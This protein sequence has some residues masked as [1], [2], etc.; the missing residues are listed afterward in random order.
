MRV[1][2][3]SIMPTITSGDTSIPT[4]M[5]AER[6]SD[7]LKSTVDCDDLIAESDVQASMPVI[8]ISRDYLEDLPKVLNPQ[9]QRR[10]DNNLALEQLKEAFNLYN[11]D[12]E[13]YHRSVT[14]KLQSRIKDLSY[15]LE[16][17]TPSKRRVSSS[18]S[19]PVDELIRCLEELKYQ[20][21]N[22]HQK[23][24]ESPSSYGRNRGGSDMLV[25][26]IL[27]A[28]NSAPQNKHPS[29]GKNVALR[30]EIPPVIKDQILEILELI[31]EDRDVSERN[32]RRSVVSNGQSL[33]IDAINQILSVLNNPTRGEVHSHAHFIDSSSANEGNNQNVLLNQV[34]SALQVAPQ[35]NNPHIQNKNDNNAI[36]NTIHTT[37]QNQLNQIMTSINELRQ[38]PTLPQNETLPSNDV[39]NNTT[40]KTQEMMNQILS[41]INDMRSSPQVS[42]SETIVSTPQTVNNNSQEAALNLIL[43]ELSEI[44]Q[45]SQQ[46]NQNHNSIPASNSKIGNSN[47]TA[48]AEIISSIN[49]MKEDI[50]NAKN[51]NFQ[52]IHVPIQRQGVAPLADQNTGQSSGTSPAIETLVLQQP[53][54]TSPQVKGLNNILAP[55]VAQQGLNGLPVGNQIVNPYLN[56]LQGQRTFEAI[57]QLLGRNPGMAQSPVPSPPFMGIPPGFLPGNR[58]PPPFPPPFIPPG[59]PPPGMPPSGMPP[60]GIPP[61]GM[62]PNPCSRTV[63]MNNINLCNGSNNLQRPLTPREMELCQSLQAAMQCQN[64]NNCRAIPPHLYNY[65]C[66]GK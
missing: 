22:E 33:P 19:S 35:T 7:I 50:K 23:T 38:I 1:V 66:N 25:N 42:T 41:A 57:S 31:K 36:N 61:P 51:L 18:S 3:A 64:T 48:L 46:L 45:N 21:Q 13:A 4:V 6:A 20:L 49:E 53:S 30:D 60:P 29:H 26:Q 52:S 28:L 55:A 63:V 32:S 65:Y 27:Y 17:L 54:N 16:D 47:D 37:I 14:D 10:S 15:A 9:L 24:I 39:K 44:R 12:K 62:P 43:K 40:D 58:M 2:D 56:L 11:R 34:F 59:M 8:S 5:I